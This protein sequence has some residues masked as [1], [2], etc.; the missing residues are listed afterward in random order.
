MELISRKLLLKTTS[1]NQY[2][3]EYFATQYSPMRPMFSVTRPYLNLLAK[4]RIFSGFL[5]KDIILM[6]FERQNAFQKAKKNRIPEKKFKKMFLPY[7]T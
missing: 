1:E 7:P 2:V 3:D 4:P 6:H 5:E